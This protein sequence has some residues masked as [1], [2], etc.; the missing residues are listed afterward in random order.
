MPMVHNRATEMAKNKPEHSEEN[1]L[2]G[3]IHP[4]RLIARMAVSSENGG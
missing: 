2:K 3:W 1:G 4:A